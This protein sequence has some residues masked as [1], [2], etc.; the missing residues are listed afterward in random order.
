MNVQTEQLTERERVFDENGAT[1]EEV[2]TDD[3][4]TEAG[5]IPAEAAVAPSTTVHAKK[6][7]IGDREFD[8]QDEALAFAQS[9]VNTLEVEAQVA[10]AYRQGIRDAATPATT[11]QPNVTQPSQVQPDDTE[12][13][14]TNPQAFLERFASKIKTETRAEIDQRD[15]LKTESDNIWRE[16]TDRHPE[17]ADFRTEVENFVSGNLTEV[18]AMIGVKGRP[19]AYD[20]VATKLKS[21]WEAY[22][23]A[24]KP[25][26][27]LPNTRTGASPG[28]PATTVTPPPRAEKPLSFSEQLRSIRKRGKP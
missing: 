10:D 5:E 3:A 23:S 9:H 18:R 25:R 2:P 1:I 15:A 27:E 21:R 8:T 20:W 4:E 14:Y 26:R 19:S 12:E 7:R 24:L 16:F 22:N 13:L 11:G 6:F 28:A 17:L